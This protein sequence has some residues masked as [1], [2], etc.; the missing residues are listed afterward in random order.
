MPLR[1]HGTSLLE[2]V[3]DELAGRFGKMDALA[4]DACLSTEVALESQSIPQLELQQIV[5]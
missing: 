2:S 4:Q 5:P 3:D 1:P